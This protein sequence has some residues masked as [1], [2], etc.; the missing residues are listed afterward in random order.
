MDISF[1]F[2]QMFVLILVGFVFFLLIVPKNNESDKKVFFHRQ[3]ITHQ[4]EKTT[5]NTLHCQ[6]KTKFLQSTIV[7]S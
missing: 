6:D 3:K 2:L 7:E 5:S 1:V 4:L